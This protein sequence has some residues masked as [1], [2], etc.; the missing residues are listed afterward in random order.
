MRISDCSSDVCSSDLLAVVLDP[1]KDI[2]DRGVRD[3]ATQLDRPCQM[4]AFGIELDKG[5]QAGIVADDFCVAELAQLAQDQQRIVAARE[6]FGLGR[7][8]ERRVG[9][10]CVSPCRS[11]WSPYH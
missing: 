1:G 10:E 3:L 11:R 2:D 8:E 6:Q 4:A 9:K 5:R 7:S